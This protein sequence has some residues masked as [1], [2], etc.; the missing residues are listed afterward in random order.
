MLQL[1]A[2]FHSTAITASYVTAW[3]DS[4]GLRFLVAF[5]LKTK[6]YYVDMYM[7]ITL[8]QIFWG[9]P[10]FYGPTRSLVYVC[11]N[12]SEAFKFNILNKYSINKQAVKMVLSN[13]FWS[14]SFRFSPFI[15]C[16]IIGFIIHCRD[17][18]LIFSG[19]K[20]DRV[21]YVWYI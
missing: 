17:F 5:N 4:F 18:D 21:R 20:C 16:T 19:I 8:K 10:Q 15:C 3:P 7:L 14:T 9:I 1:H 13:A 2:L 12:K 6:T 11:I